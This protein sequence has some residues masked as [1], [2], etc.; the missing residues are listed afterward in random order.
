[1]SRIVAHYDYIFLVGLGG[2]RSGKHRV[3]SREGKGRPG[4]VQFSGSFP[5]SN[6]DETYST[7]VINEDWWTE[8]FGERNRLP[9]MDTAEIAAATLVKTCLGISYGCPL[10]AFRTNDADLA[11]KHIHTHINKFISQFRLEVIEEDSN[12]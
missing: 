7:L 10:C 2:H 12:D 1:M 11:K 5:L 6:P 8:R 9:N 4:T 3:T